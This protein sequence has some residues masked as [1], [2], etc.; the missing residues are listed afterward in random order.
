MF[1]ATPFIIAKTCKQPKCPTIDGYIKKIWH[2]YKG[3]LL[4][5]KKNEIMPFVA[6]WID[7]EIIIL[8][9]VRKRKTDT[10]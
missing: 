5:H 8:S 1:I 9:E 10:V 6:K 2:I 3:I 7:L 4:S